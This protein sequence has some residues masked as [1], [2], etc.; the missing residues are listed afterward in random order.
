MGHRVVL[1][2]IQI[3]LL[4]LCS[5]T[6]VASLVYFSVVL[7]DTIFTQVNDQGQP[8]FYM[9]KA[10]FM[11]V[12]TPMLLPVFLVQFHER[13]RSPRILRAACEDLNRQ[14]SRLGLLRDPL[15]L[16]W[17]ALAYYGFVLFVFLM[18]GVSNYRQMGT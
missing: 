4:L 18:I 14:E 1:S 9:G 15:V 17:I 11:A 13:I 3:G 7:P 5:V 12:Y 6:Y 10:L 8:T 16:R 2:R